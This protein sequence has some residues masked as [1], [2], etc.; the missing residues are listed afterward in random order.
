MFARGQESAYRV[1]RIEDKTVYGDFVVRPGKNELEVAPG[2]SRTIELEIENR[3]GES[4]TYLLSVED[5]AGSDDGSHAAVLLGSDIGPYTLKKYVEVPDAPISLLHGE[6]ALVPVTI[7]VPETADPGGYYG[8]VL[9][10]AEPESGV[11]DTGNVTAG[12]PLIARVAALLF[13]TVPG[14]TNREGKLRD[15]DVV[16]SGERIFERGPITFSLSYENSGSVH[17][18]PYGEVRITD[19]FGNEV[20]FIELE[21]WYALPGSLRFREVVW[22]ETPFIGRFTATT[23]INR[24]YDNVVDTRA[25]HFWIIPWKFVLGALILFALLFFGFIRLFR[26]K[27]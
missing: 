8:S 19:M 23:K 27:K 9:V 20:A 22:G 2:E 26:K 5:V 6:R 24:G 13:V 10:S 17:L 1:E 3:T 16:P 11:G 12:A 15:F 7:S 14:R 4:A 21:P 25:V 18:N